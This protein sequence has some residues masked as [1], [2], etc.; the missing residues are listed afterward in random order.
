M[1]ERWTSDYIPANGMRFIICR[2]SYKDTDYTDY[3]IWHYE[4]PE[5][6][7]KDRRGEKSPHGNHQDESIQYDLEEAMELL[8]EDFG[9]PVDSWFE[10]D[11]AGQQ[12]KKK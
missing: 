8:Y 1:Q 6:Y 12:V 11:S 7:M 10:I 3:W 4:V 9:V 2:E 5:L